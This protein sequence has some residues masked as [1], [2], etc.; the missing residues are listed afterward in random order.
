MAQLGTDISRT[1]EELIDA[2]NHGDWNRLRPLV[3]EDLVYTES[4]TGRRVE[5][6]DAYF[7]L[8]DGWK[9]AFPDVAGTV[10]RTLTGD[11]IVAQ[12]IHWTGTQSGPLE[13]PGGTVAATGREI[14]VDAS[15][16]LRF[17]GDRIG[18][19]HHHLDA[20]MLLQQIGALPQ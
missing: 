20:L 2:F 12:E 11:G 9:R 19:I 13:I 10:T 17:R 14:S 1:A 16:W 6:A 8:L 3:A 7:E 4:G 5:G 18:E 15:A